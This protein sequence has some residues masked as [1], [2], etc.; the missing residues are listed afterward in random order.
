[1][2]LISRPLALPWE[3]LE[4]VIEHSSDDLDLLRSFSLTCRQLRP[5]SFTL[6]LAQYVF[7]NSRDKAFDF[8]D[9][10]LEHPKLQPLIH[11]IIISPADFRPF[12]LVNMLPRLS[13]LLFTPPGYQKYKFHI[14]PN[15]RGDLPYSEIHHATINCYHLFGRRIHTLSLDHL[16]FQ[17]SSDL[18]RLLLAFPMT[19]QL[20][21]NN[22]F[23]KFTEKQTPTV[24]RNKLS[25]QLR[26][27]NLHVRIHS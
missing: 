7:L 19:T 9:F 26:L 22:I 25:K 5:R 24:V 17:T 13:T 1:M 8:V 11:S 15:D 27:Q 3:I 16:S 21:C 6:I 20:S 2:P 14:G 23:I 12:P 18:F 4:R 10:L